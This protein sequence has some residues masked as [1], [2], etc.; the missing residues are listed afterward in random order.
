GWPDGS[1][2]E[3]CSC[4]LGTRHRRGTW[5]CPRRGTRVPIHHECKGVSLHCDMRFRTMYVTDTP[6]AYGHALRPHEERSPQRVG[7]TVAWVQGFPD[8]GHDAM[9]G[10]GSPKGRRA[11]WFAGGWAESVVKAPDRFWRRR[12]RPQT[13]RC[14]KLPL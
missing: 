3:H 14:K 4:P 10:R 13:C 2:D 11:L 7:R 1:F 8:L 6:R 9:T 5:C 12:G